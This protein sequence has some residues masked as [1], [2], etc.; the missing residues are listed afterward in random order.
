MDEQKTTHIERYMVAIGV[1][2]LVALGWYYHVV[3]RGTPPAGSGPAGPAVPA[4]PFERVWGEGDTVLL[5]VG[6]SITRGFGA[7]PGHSYFELLQGNDD[8]ACPDMAGREL[9]RVF[10]KLKAVNVAVNYST[11]VA[12][13]QHQVPGITPFGSDVKGIVAVTSGGNDLIH[14]YGRKPPED[15]AMYGCS[16]EQAKMWEPTIR[17][18]LSGIIDRVNARFPGGCQIFLANIYDPTDGV[19]DIERASVPLPAWPDGLKVLALWNQAIAQACDAYD[20][21]HLVDI[22]ALFLGHGLHCR[23]RGNPHYRSQDPHYWYFENLEDP[24]DRGYD[25]IRRAFLLK[26]IEVFQKTREER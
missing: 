25:A 15:G 23:D 22:H 18:R 1:V 13:V 19:G 11:S 8:A 3:V 14:P 10:P 12:H 6:D 24:N 2:L 9:T 4:E 16:I 5:G 26:M 20:N 7:S 17:K 21:V